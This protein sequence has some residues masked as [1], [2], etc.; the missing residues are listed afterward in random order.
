MSAM[1]ACLLVASHDLLTN[2]EVFAVAVDALCAGYKDCSTCLSSGASFTNGSSAADIC[3]AHVAGDQPPNPACLAPPQALNR[4]PIAHTLDQL[5]L[6]LSANSQ[7]LHSQSNLDG[8]DQSK[9]PRPRN[10]EFSCCHLQRLLQ[11]CLSKACMVLVKHC[12]GQKLRASTAWCF[13]ELLLYQCQGY[14]CSLSF[15]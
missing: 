15:I 2:L 6:L 14:F 4:T 13:L 12:I 8:A 11:G 5:L 9:A 7:A 3:C 1:H 10:V